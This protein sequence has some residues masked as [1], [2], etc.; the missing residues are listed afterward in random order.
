LIGGGAPE[1]QGWRRRRRADPE[2][3]RRRRKDEIGGVRRRV[4]AYLK[5]T[6]LDLLISLLIYENMQA[7]LRK[8]L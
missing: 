5:Q 3:Q 8:T 7:E 6:I 1:V 2:S 4:S